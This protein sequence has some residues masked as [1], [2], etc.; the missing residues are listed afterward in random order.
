[1]RSSPAG[2]LPLALLL[3]VADAA[4]QSAVTSGE[5]LHVDVSPARDELVIN[6]LGDLWTVPTAGGVASQLAESAAPASRPRWSPDARQVAFEIRVPGASSIHVL[7][8]ESGEQRQIGDSGSAEQHPAWH[9]SGE[10]L[11]YASRRDGPDFDLHEVDLATGLDWQLTHD[12]ADDIEP[13][14]SADGRD[15]VWVRQTAE[16]WALMLRPFGQPPRSL[17]RSDTPIRAPSWRPDGTLVTYFRERDGRF[18]L[19]M[20]I[21]SDPPIDRTLVS[22]AGLHPAPVSWLDRSRLFYSTGNRIR[23]RGFDDWNGRTVAFR[24]TPTP[25]ID[26]TP[27]FEVAAR[28][29]PLIRPAEGE[30]VYRAGRLFDGYSRDYREAVDVLVRD[31]RIAEIVP[32]RDWDD[33]PVIDLPTT[34]M[35]PGYVDAHSRLPSADAVEAGPRLL[36]WGVTTIV[37]PPRE[38]LDPTAWE[39]GAPPGPRLLTSTDI[40]PPPAEPED[41]EESA[42][43]PFLV[44]ANGSDVGAEEKREFTGAWQERG[45]PVLAE[46]WSLAAKLD[47]YLLAAA[48]TASAASSGDLGAGRIGFRRQVFDLSRRQLISGLADRRTDGILELLRARQ[49]GDARPDLPRGERVPLLADLRRSRQ[50]VV[51]GSAGNGFAPG[52]A[53][54]AELLALAG[55]GLAGDQVL[56]AAGRNAAS[57]LGL[58]GEI[59]EISVGARAD[60]VFVSGDPLASIH[61]ARNI[62]AVVRNGHFYSMVNLLERG[63]ASVE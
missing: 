12:P 59:G 51:L 19:D 9:P 56:K 62:I 48:Q 18:D 54:H 10:R 27:A 53:L 4:A 55:A 17:I 2:L 15:L 58:A 32:R 16:N 35:L 50:P 3:G 46:D 7:D 31:G 34:T 22:E 42:P 11:V 29:L 30:V 49:T 1:V 28:E 5:D 52:L 47:S 13:A 45:I 21:R 57:L 20:L 63:R 6:L 8:V 36:A 23:T 60:L 24:A 14:W 61:A 40:G 33:M 44:V 43:L 38:G 37:A 25:A 26:E 39:S 41:G